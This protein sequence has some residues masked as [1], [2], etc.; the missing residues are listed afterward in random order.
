MKKISFTLLLLCGLFQTLSAQNVSGSDAEIQ[1]LLCKTWTVVAGTTT[2]AFTIR[3]DTDG[4]YTLKSATEEKTDRWRYKEAQAQIINYRDAQ[5][6]NHITTL[7]ENEIIMVM[8]KVNG[9]ATVHL[10]PI[11]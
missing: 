1:K 6:D 9:N 4:T 10:K 3:F 5:V 2:P 8:D 7:T 11:Q